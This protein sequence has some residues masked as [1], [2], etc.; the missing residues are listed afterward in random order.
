[1][2]GR[3]FDVFCSKF[4]AWKDAES[5]YHEKL[6]IPVGPVSVRHISRVPSISLPASSE[7]QQEPTDP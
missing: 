3:N 5:Y 7:H 6:K 4:T 2:A 1:M